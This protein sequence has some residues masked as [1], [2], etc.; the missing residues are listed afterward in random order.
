MAKDEKRVQVEVRGHKIWV[1]EHL[2]KDMLRMG[3]TTD[4]RI[5]RN[6]PRELLKRP[7]ELLPKMILTEKGPKVVTPVVSEV[8][9][10]VVEKPKRKTPVKSRSK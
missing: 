10:E 5:P 8:A 4:T 9:P 1:Q 6:I 7:V 3:A 2:V